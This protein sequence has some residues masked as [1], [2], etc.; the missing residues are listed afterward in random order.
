MTETVSIFEE[1]NRQ[2]KKAE[3]SG[4]LPDTLSVA[5]R[6]YTID[7]S[8]PPTQKIIRDWVN[9]RRPED[10]RKDIEHEYVTIDVAPYANEIRLNDVIYSANRTYLLPVFMTDQ[11]REICQATWRHEAQTGGANSFGMNS[12]KK[13]GLRYA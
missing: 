9:P 11:I 8:S 1:L 3:K 5:G 10:V 13:A 12:V 4:Q 7:G 6:T 2:I